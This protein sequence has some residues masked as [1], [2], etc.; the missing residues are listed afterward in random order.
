[1]IR[2]MIADDQALVRHGFRL[3]LR[4]EA[5]IEVVGEAAN[6][7]EAVDGAARLRPD[8]ILM[9]VR[10]PV[11]DGIAAT[12]EIVASGA[13]SRVLILTTFDLDEHVYD[14]LEAGASGF[15]LKDLEPARLAEAVR[16][17]AQGEA[18]LAP[19]VTRRLIADFARRRPAPEPSF[20]LRDLTE[21]EAEVLRLLARG[22]SNQ[23][24]AADLGVSDTTIKTHVAHVLGKLD[25]RDRI[26]AVIL[27]YET[28]LVRPASS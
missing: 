10:M 23:E 24:I 4:D 11:L 14:A 13:P 5:G 28:G 3:I 1:V 8:V 9:D 17:V 12:R 7:R 2:V 6:G 22:H 15:L 20:R 21:R 27:A 19:S 25:L 18:L 26:Q 16:V